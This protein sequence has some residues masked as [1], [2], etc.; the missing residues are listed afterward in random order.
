MGEG[1]DFARTRSA[2]LRKLGYEAGLTQ[3]RPDGRKTRRRVS[4]E[5]KRRQERNPIARTP[6]KRRE[7]G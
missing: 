5:A 3:V 6:Y 7:R 2:R 4:P 1:A